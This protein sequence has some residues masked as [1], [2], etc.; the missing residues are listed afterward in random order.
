MFHCRQAGL[1]AIITLLDGCVS[2][3]QRLD[4]YHHDARHVR[5]LDWSES[6]LVALFFAL[7][8][9]T[10]GQLYIGGVPKGEIAKTL[11]CSK[12]TVTRDVKWLKRLWVEETIKDPVEHRARTLATLY[13]LEREA[14]EKYISTGSPR[15]W[16]RWLRA[17]VSTS[18]FLGLDTPAKLDAKIDTE[19]VS[20]TIEFE[21]REPTR[22][23]DVSS[24]GF[25]LGAKSIM[26]CA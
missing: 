14:A 24:D 18:K 16:D 25:A 17:V 23:I 9:R 5:L 7:R 8:R 11:C 2:L 13:E 21:T 26:E 20:F 3:F 1:Q 15:W 6:P 4:G 22:M 10:V 19:D 12:Q